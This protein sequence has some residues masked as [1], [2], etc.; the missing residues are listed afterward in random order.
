MVG[1]DGSET[2]NMLLDI[3]KLKSLG[4]KPR[5]NSAETVRQAVKEILTL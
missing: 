1:E 2:K 3:S 5:Y 4:W